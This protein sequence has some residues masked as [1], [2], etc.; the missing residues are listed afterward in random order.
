MLD[1]MSVESA[2]GY[3]DIARSEGGN[4][5]DGGRLKHVFNSG[6]RLQYQSVNIESLNQLK[7]L[8]LEEPRSI[9]PCSVGRLKS[10]LSCLIWQSLAS[11]RC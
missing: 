10:K 6:M 9:K 2:S 7:Y 1:S 11:V 8:L 4:L 3:G 5:T